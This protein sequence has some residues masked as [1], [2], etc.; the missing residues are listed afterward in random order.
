MK[1][2]FQNCFLLLFCMLKL[3]LP[4]YQA[5]FPPFFY[6]IFPLIQVVRVGSDCA[7]LNPGLNLTERFSSSPLSRESSLAASGLNLFNTKTGADMKFELRHDTP[8]PLS[9][10]DTLNLEVANHTET[11]QSIPAH[12]VV[13]CAR[14]PWFLRALTSGMREERERKIV[15][16]DC[17]F[18]TFNLFLK[19][20]NILPS[21]LYRV[22]LPT[23][24]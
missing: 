1:R 16:R 23:S 12:R 2:H 8:S 5:Q 17:D 13:V 6:Y 7:E 11:V 3:D 4:I 21:Y 18:D 9:Y 20:I 15:L 22:S 14:C 19:V 10:T 24:Y